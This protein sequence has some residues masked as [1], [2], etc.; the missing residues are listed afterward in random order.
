MND[1]IKNPLFI[2]ASVSFLYNI[3][4][5]TTTQFFHITVDP[6]TWL[7]FF[8]L[9]LWLVLGVGVYSNYAPS[10]TNVQQPIQYQ[11]PLITAPT[12]APVESAVT[13]ASIPT[14]V[15]VETPV[16]AHDV[17]VAESPQV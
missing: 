12:I 14:P 3:T 1:R 17:V 16:A 6:A 5:Y 13:S 2:A 4:N 9:L 10:Q 11:Q 7:T 15:T 8:N